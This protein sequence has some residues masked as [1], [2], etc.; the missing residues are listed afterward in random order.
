MRDDTAILK[1]LENKA[2]HY[3]GRYASTE[4]R[5]RD[6]LLRFANRKMAEEDPERIRLLIE[7][8]ITNC[9]AK[10]YVNDKS[11]AEQKTASL[12]QK[13]A[14]RFQ[15]KQKLYGRGVDGGII[16][17]TLDNHD[18]NQGDNAE[19]Q[20]AL[21]Y[22]RRRRL[23]PY[24]CPKTGQNEMK[25]GWQK[26]HYASLAR[27]GFSHKIA[28]IIMTLDNADDADAMVERGIFD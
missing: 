23:G 8:T 3:L 9:A 25:D 17:E 24:A 10:G 6:V 14:S 28:A 7:H 22:A 4:A 20:A 2:L 1:R 26:R 16:D 27:A 11:F 15:I 13:G 18:A 5:L 21:I 19:I 12:R